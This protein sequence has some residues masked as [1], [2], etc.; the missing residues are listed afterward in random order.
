VSL[1]V[2]HS[3]AEGVAAFL[4]LDSLS[5][6]VSGSIS[7]TLKDKHLCTIGVEANFSGR[8]DNASCSMSGGAELNFSFDGV[9]CA[10][11]CGSGPDS[12][13]PCPVAIG[14]ETTWQATL[15]DGLLTG[16]IGGDNCEPGCVG[17]MGN[18]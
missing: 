17:F 1:T 5:Q 4:S 3:D 18:P 13:R 12:E 8:F 11:V 2:L 7:Y 9:A 6:N 16:G 14:G 10:S 15:E